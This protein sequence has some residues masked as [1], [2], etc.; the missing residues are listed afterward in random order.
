MAKIEYYSLDRILKE[1]ADYNIIIGE[2]GNG[3]SYQIKTRRALGNYLE[4]VS[5][6]VRDILPECFKD[7]KRF[8][9]LRR[10]REEIS[11]DQV[12]N[13]FKDLNISKIT[14]GKY[15]TI[16]CYRK[17]IYF[18]N[19]DSDGKVKNGEL[20]GYVVALSTEQNYA[21]NMFLD[22]SDMIFEEFMSRTLY[23]KNEVTKLMN[24][25]ATV[26]RKRH[27]T[28]LWLVGNTVTRVNPY[29]NEWGLH[30]ILSKMHP[31]DLKTV[32]I[33]TSDNDVVKIAIEFCK[34]TGVS[35]HVIGS[36]G[37][38]IN[39]GKWETRPQPH[40]PKSKNDYK[41]EFRF[42]FKYQNFKFI[43]ELLSDLKTH[44]IA[45]FI[46]PYEGEIDNKTLVITDE[47]NISP[48]YQRNIY[49]LSINNDRLKMILS[50][51]FREQ[52]IFY[53]DDLTGTDFK[54]VVDFVI[55][56]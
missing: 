28:K 7:G 42:I 35:S 44:N 46:Y 43:C 55:R 10:L 36:S 11:N 34:P 20:I 50:T 54:Q 47:I 53:S 37:S 26:D 23:L 14:D 33:K 17:K 56:R 16:N 51:T 1:D 38:M 12:M 39:E 49:D 29:V 52:N 18:A 31:G 30:D 4:S 24:L 32:E 8:M 6:K 19:L 27:T 13:Y 15:S 22:V 40:L 41:V 25:Y 21:S 48:L 45:Y 3:K 5:D 2:K 9:L